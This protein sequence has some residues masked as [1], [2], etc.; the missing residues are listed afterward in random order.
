MF[1]ALA[2]QKLDSR[3][4]SAL[5]NYSRIEKIG[6]G[7]YGVVYKG[8]DKRSGKMVAMKKIRLENEDEGVPATAIRE[9]SLLRE[10]T[11]PNIVGLEEIILEENRL[12]LIFEFLHMDL[13]KYIDTIPDSE[14]MDK[15]LQKSYLY[16][17]LQAICFCH[18]RRVLHRDLKPQNL[19]VDK[20]GA[21]KLADFGLARAIGIP[22]RAYTH[23]IVT[24]WYRAPEVLL[25]AT[26][27]SMGVDIWSIGC[28]AAEMATKVPLFQGDSEI[29]QIFR[30]F[31]IMSTPTEDIWHGVTQ[32][33]DF[34]MSF[35]QWKEDGLRKILDTYM[36]PEG[37][38]ILRDMLI[39]DPAQRISA[40]KLLKSPYF[41][42]VDRKKLPA[43]DYDGTLVIPPRRV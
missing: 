43:G 16:Q 11:H 19:L 20:N 14:L 29:D 32:L 41:D 3:E 24:L 5:Q 21:I 9:I 4:I 42:D 22:I 38:E 31:R 35:P 23:E 34:K 12:Y 37:I 8:I 17:I 26:R 2:L 7:T 30:I 13:K 15:T 33:P 1:M 25:G 28:I 36:D 40:K 10:L 27:Y 6:E 39:Y 18:Q